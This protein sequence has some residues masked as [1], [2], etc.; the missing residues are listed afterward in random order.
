MNSLL[1]VLMQ[2]PVWFL[3]GLCELVKESFAR[4]YLCLK[5]LFWDS[6]LV[7]AKQRLQEQVPCFER[8]CRARASS[9]GKSAIQRDML[10]LVALALLAPMLR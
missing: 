7:Q 6:P 8:V 1:F 5:I 9:S 10:M 3:P 4:I 2:A